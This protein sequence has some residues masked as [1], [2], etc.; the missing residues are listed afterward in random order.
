MPVRP[1]A[2]TSD[3]LIEIENLVGSAHADTLQGNDNDNVIEGETGA[4]TLTGLGGSDTFVLH[5]FFGDDTISDFNATAGPSHD[6]IQF[7]TSEFANFADV[8][9]WAAQVGND[10]LIQ[11]GGDSLTLT[12]VVL[13][14]LSAD[15]FVFV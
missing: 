3:S 9:A 15:D 4:D 11:K 14:N 7:D 6:I 12:N 13:G 2:S 1:P 5:S 10:V 8:Q